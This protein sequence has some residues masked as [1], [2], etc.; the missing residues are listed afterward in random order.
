MQKKGESVNDIYVCGS[1][2][3][4]ETLAFT[5]ISTAEDPSNSIY[6]ALSDPK[7]TK[8]GYLQMRGQLKLLLAEFHL[9]R[10]ELLNTS[11][12]LQVYKKKANHVA[13]DTQADSK[14]AKRRRSSPDQS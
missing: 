10:I 14:P 8:E 4:S 2:Y 13:D 5:P 7:Y 11:T 3:S 6:Q 1:F 9:Q 12:E